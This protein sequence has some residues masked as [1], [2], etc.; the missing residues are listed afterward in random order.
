MIDVNQHGR[1]GTLVGRIGIGRIGDM[2]RKRKILLI[3]IPCTA[4]VIFLV[5]FLVIMELN[6]DD[7]PK[8]SK[9][10]ENSNVGGEHMP[11]STPTPET[12]TPETYKN[13]YSVGEILRL[14]RYEQ[15]G[16]KSNGSE[17]IEW[18]VLDVKEDELLII[19]RY[20]L[21]C[22]AFHNSAED[23][24]WESSNVRAWLND[25]FFNEAFTETEKSWV[26]ETTIENKDFY[27]GLDQEGRLTANNTG[28]NLESVTVH[29]AGGDITSDKVFLLSIDEVNSL[30]EAQTDRLCRFTDYAHEKYIENSI[31][32]A[33]KR[34]ITDETL[35]REKLNAW[36]QMYGVG[37]SSWWL[38]SSGINRTYAGVVDLEGVAYNSLLCTDRNGGVRPVMKV[39]LPKS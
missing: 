9:R 11:D 30:I 21:E 1:V 35:L 24:I 5:A 32:E 28:E 15:D 34:G 4:L 3:A 29:T 37:T 14:G 8:A 16:Q 6:K 31:E 33:K 13:S 39:T 12:Y 7:P 10:G 2:N 36:E 23:V 17:A 38:R 26:M 20:V 22:M 25:S 18:I 27:L 19:S